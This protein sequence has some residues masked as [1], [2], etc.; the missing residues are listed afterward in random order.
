MTGQSVTESRVRSRARSWKCF[1]LPC[2]DVTRGIIHGFT[3]FEMRLILILFA[4]LVAAGGAAVLL[5]P[6]SAEAAMLN[7]G[8]IAPNFS[9]EAIAG[10]QTIPVH[11]VDYRGRRIVL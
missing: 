2:T 5:R 7:V 11:L 10:D 9:A 1:A 4:I 8:D 6:R 3:T